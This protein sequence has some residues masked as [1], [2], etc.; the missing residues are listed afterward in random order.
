MGND[1]TEGIW[2]SA[3][4]TGGEL[5]QLTGRIAGCEGRVEQ[6]LAGIRDTQLLTWESPAG[7]AYRDALSVQ[8]A[9]LRSAVRWLEDARQAVGRRAGEQVPL[10]PTGSGWPG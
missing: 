5:Q 7:R 10:L 3:Q 9:A 4:R 6:V 8:A 2:G 1:V